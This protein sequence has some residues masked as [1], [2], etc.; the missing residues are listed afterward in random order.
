MNKLI[1]YADDT[2]QWI[3]YL[4][5]HRGSLKLIRTISRIRS[6]PEKD[7]PQEWIVWNSMQRAWS[8]FSTLKGALLFMYR[9]TWIVIQRN[10]YI[11]RRA[12]RKWLKDSL[13]VIS[14]I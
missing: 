9:D 2:L 7:I 3:G 10:K 8:T 6:F 5:W 13:K 11:K 14:N 12:D 4:K 1:I